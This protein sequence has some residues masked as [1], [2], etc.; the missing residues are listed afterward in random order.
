M[1]QDTQQVKGIGS[2]R[3]QPLAAVDFVNAA[4]H[5]NGTVDISLQYLVR[6][7]QNLHQRSVT[8]ANSCLHGVYNPSDESL[9]SN[10][11]RA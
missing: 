2:S 10:V 5:P 7:R 11:V 6:R 4:G 9:V 1:M 8:L 3:Q